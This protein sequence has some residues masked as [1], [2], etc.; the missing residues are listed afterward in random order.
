MVGLRVREYINYS[1]ILNIYEEISKNVKHKNKLK[2][3]ERNKV[4]NINTTLNILNSNTYDGGKYEIFL[5]SEPIQAPLLSV[6]QT[7]TPYFSNTITSITSK[8][9]KQEINSNI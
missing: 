7:S 4:Q 6:R 5:I 2:V 9:L 8:S 3:F 1:N